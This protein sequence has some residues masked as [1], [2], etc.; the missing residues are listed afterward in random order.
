MGID[1]PNIRLVIHHSMP[2]DIES[3]LQEIGR[4]GRD[5]LP[6]RCLLL[7]STDDFLKH[8]SFAY[9]PTLATAQLYLLLKRIFIPMPT[10]RFFLQETIALDL[11]G[12]ADDL[13]ISGLW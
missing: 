4:A 12:S 2:K 10:G 7:L 6:S 13:D 8:H 11:D 5:G 1:K 3:Y 9:S